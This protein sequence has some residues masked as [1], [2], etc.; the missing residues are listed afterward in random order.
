[1]KL[2]LTAAQRKAGVDLRD[3]IRGA[4]ITPLSASDRRRMGGAAIMR[5]STEVRAAYSTPGAVRWCR[6]HNAL[7]R[8]ESDGTVSVKVNGKTRRRP[9]LTD[10]VNALATA[11]GAT[12]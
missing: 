4:T 9:I 3:V 8:F 1:M 11:L 6:E 2:K 12:P 5:I 7:V 10:A